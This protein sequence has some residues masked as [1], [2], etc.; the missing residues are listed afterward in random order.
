MDQVEEEPEYKRGRDYALRRLGRRECSAD[1]LRRKI[2][3]QGIS[4]TIAEKI[5]ENL[6]KNSLVSDE[7]FSR[8]LIRQQVSRSNGPRLIRQKLKAQGIELDA[9]Q[10]RE[11]SAEVSERSEVETA[12]AFVTRKYPQCWE[13]T[14]VAS[15]A[16]QALLRRGFSYSVIEDVLRRR[17]SFPKSKVGNSEM[18]VLEVPFTPL[19]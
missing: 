14:K 8:M 10:V 7:R 12:H 11:I 19:V 2:Q 6:L 15:R 9:E 18:N 17:A 16:S 5:V 13:D 3:Q 1:D 4:G